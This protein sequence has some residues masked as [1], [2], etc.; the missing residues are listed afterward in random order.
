VIL[1]WFK[2]IKEQKMEKELFNQI[3]ELMQDLVG[4]ENHNHKSDVIAKLFRLHNKVFL[5]R[6]EYSQSCSGCRQRV[7]NRLK[8]WWIENNGV[9]K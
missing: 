1:E 4:R 3:D 7:Y 6:P 5:D 8:T 2:K 9:K